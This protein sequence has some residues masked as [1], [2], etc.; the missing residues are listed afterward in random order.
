MDHAEVARYSWGFKGA[1]S[2][3]RVQLNGVLCVVLICLLL[4]LLIVGLSSR[5]S[6]SVSIFGCVSGFRSLCSS[7]YATFHCLLQYISC[8]AGWVSNPTGILKWIPTH[9]KD[10][11]LLGI[12][13]GWRTIS[14]LS[15]SYSEN[16]SLQNNTI[17]S[18]TT[19]P[20]WAP[21]L[22]ATV[23]NEWNTIEHN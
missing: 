22:Y 14:A 7:L 18:Q 10:G 8:N 4:C 11:W 2:F 23:R 13:V 15:W 1:R 21:V 5:P 19:K 6:S 17:V 3:W 12:T 16:W 20:A 9:V